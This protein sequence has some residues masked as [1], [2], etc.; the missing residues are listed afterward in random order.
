MCTLPNLSQTKV[1]KQFLTLPVAVLNT[2]IPIKDIRME[3]QA[4]SQEEKN[5]ILFTA[6]VWIQYTNDDTYQNP[7]NTPSILLGYKTS[8]KVFFKHQFRQ[9]QFEFQLLSCVLTVKTFYTLTPILKCA[10]RFFTHTILQIGI[11]TLLSKTI[12]ISK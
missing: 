9:Q 2:K 3:K 11:Q 10:L 7:L 5:T 6:S 8:S 12:S 1:H 4:L